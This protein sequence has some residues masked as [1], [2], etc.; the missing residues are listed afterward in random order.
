MGVVGRGWC[1]ER[2]A[3][4]GG[5]GGGKGESHNLHVGKVTGNVAISLI[6]G[7]WLFPRRGIRISCFEVRGRRSVREEPDFDVAAG[8]LC[9]ND[10]ASVRV[11]ILAVRLRVLIL[12]ITAGICRLARCV[13]VA[14]RGSQSA[15]EI[16]IIGDGAA[17]RGV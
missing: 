7:D 6:L 5:K 12:N 3:E 13:A 14:I 8:P 9:D 11:E 15:G 1:G 17:V 10:T 16:A 2:E 4:V